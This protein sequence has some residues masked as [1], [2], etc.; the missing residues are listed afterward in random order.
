MPLHIMYIRGLYTHRHNL[1]E[2]TNDSL[3]YTPMSTKQKAKYNTCECIQISISN[4]IIP[5]I[6]LN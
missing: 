1:L 5:I 3:C 4:L 6:N 2:Y